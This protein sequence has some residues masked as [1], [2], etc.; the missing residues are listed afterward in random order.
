MTECPS[1][2]TRE[3]E[4]LHTQMIRETEMALSRSQGEPV[5]QSSD[6][7]PEIESS[8]AS[9]SVGECRPRTEINL[10][11]ATRQFV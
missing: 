11:A 1:Y 3:L 8:D 9:V 2:W 7:T 10:A 6:M 4:E 5:Q